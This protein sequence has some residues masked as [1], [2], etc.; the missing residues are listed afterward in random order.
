MTLKA[1][2]LFIASYDDPAHEFAFKP[3]ELIINGVSI[4]NIDR[5]ETMINHSGLLQLNFYQEGNLVAKDTVLDG[6]FELLK[7]NNNGFHL[8][9]KIVKTNSPGRP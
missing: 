3:E 2:L 9:Y 7:V 8:L 4:M 1:D 6:C 5:V